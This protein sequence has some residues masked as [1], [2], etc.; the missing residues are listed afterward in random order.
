MRVF[1][2]GDFRPK[3][4]KGRTWVFRSTTAIVPGSD[5]SPKSRALL[6]ASTGL[7]GEFP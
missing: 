2:E 5:T 1:A 6:E 3:P 4:D 7:I